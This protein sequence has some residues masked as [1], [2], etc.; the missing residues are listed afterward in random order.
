[1]SK[2]NRIHLAPLKKV[3]CSYGV[4]WDSVLEHVLDHFRDYKGEHDEEIDVWKMKE[5]I[6]HSVMWPY[7]V[8]TEDDDL[9]DFVSERMALEFM[10]ALGKIPG[11]HFSP[12]R[13][14]LR[15][16]KSEPTPDSW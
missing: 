10:V 13:K 9:P 5:F 11:I 7:F 4:P 12:Q 8:D 16:K 1:M 2:I 3:S 14:I 6:V 15:T